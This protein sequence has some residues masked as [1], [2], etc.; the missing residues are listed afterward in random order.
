MTTVLEACSCPKYFTVVTWDW[1]RPQVPVCHSHLQE[2]ARPSA[3]SSIARHLLP[4]DASA[5]WIVYM[6]LRTMALVCAEH[7]RET[8]CCNQS[9]QA[10]QAT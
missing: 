10:A 1:H 9:G 7:L 8:S 6:P 4:G 3:E 2:E 5:R